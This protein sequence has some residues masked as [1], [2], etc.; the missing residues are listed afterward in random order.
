MAKYQQLPSSCGPAA[1][2]NALQSL[3]IERSEAEIA[4]LAG[5]TN[6]GTSAEGLLKALKQIA[7]STGRPTPGTIYE[8]RE[9]ITIL[10]IVECLRNGRPLIL[11]VTENG[12]GW[13]HWVAAVGCLGFIAPSIIIADSAHQERFVF[14]GVAEL[15]GWLRAPGEK[16]PFYAII[17]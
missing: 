8:S 17:V 15:I 13:G 9:D 11:C 1:V 14:K 2:S 4:A 5:T 3:G 6:N 10:K 12:E 7:E 16:K